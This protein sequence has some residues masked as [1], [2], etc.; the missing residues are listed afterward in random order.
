MSCGAVLKVQEGGG[1]GIG[2]V[3]W[4][5]VA[6][7]GVMA[8]HWFSFSRP[9]SMTCV[10]SSMVM[11]VSAMFVA[12]TILRWLGRV[13][14]KI[15]CWSPEVSEECSGRNNSSFCRHTVSTLSGS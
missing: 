12:T 6:M 11:L 2:L 5:C 8:T 13:G 10:T 7:Q 14:T 15:R 4:Q 9:V 3:T 1:G